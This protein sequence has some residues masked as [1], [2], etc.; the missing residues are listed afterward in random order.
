MRTELTIH[1]QKSQTAMSPVGYETTALA[2]LQLTT[3]APRFREGPLRMRCPAF[4]NIM[5]VDSIPL[6]MQAF[7]VAIDVCRQG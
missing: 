6:V 1:S 3:E 5:G 2:K 4:A 7:E